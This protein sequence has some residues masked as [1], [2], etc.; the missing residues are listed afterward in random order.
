MTDSTNL[1][2]FD[3]MPG[4]I[5]LHAQLAPE[6]AA[7]VAAG[8]RLS[9]AQLDELMDRIAAALQRDGIRP[10]D[11]VA[12]CAAASVE[13]VALFLGA[14]RAGAVV[15]PLAPRATPASLQRMLADADVKLLFLDASVEPGEGGPP[16]IALDG[17]DAGRALSQWLESAGQPAPVEVQPEWPFNIIYSSGTTG[18][19]KGIVQPH[20]MRWATSCGSLMPSQAARSSQGDET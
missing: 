4:R 13:Y 15:A 14:L 1:P 10:G 20:S 7:L 19:P 9:Y 3:T 16:R 2:G 11:A 18:E 8:R 6:R 12:V 5:R 17:S